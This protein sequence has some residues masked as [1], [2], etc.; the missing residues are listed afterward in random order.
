MDTPKPMNE[1]A[2]KRKSAIGDFTLTSVVPEETTGEAEEFMELMD[3]QSFLHGKLS[4]LQ[5][6]AE[7]YRSGL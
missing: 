2:F 1:T 6:R 7:S 4:I 3:L 5:K